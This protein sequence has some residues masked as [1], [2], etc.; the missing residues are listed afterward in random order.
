MIL[1]LIASHLLAL[2]APMTQLAQWSD[3][4]FSNSDWTK[5]K[6]Y[7]GSTFDDLVTMTRRSDGNVGGCVRTVITAHTPTHI[8]DR[9]FAADMY[10]SAVW[11]LSSGA[12]GTVNVEMDTRLI[13]G[14]GYPALGLVLK[15]GS[16]FYISMNGTPAY[17]TELNVWETDGYQLINYP[18][19]SF[20]RIDPVT[21]A[22]L[23]TSHPDFTATGGDIQF[24]FGYWGDVN[25][26]KIPLVGTLD[27]DNW[28][29]TLFS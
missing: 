13:T 19:S 22:P 27:I 14:D 21:L 8:G 28:K 25:G 18:S 26:T 23:L 10:N 17:P 5:T 3:N 1:T 29:V 20:A 4:G 24:G 15:Q 9:Y 2:S 7:Y 6:A 12:I 11:S 16:D